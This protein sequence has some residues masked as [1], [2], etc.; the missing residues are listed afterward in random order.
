MDVLIIL[1]F[2]VAI[3]LCCMFLWAFLFFLNRFIVD[4][5]FVGKLA[6]PDPEADDIYVELDGQKYHRRY[7]NWMEWPSANRISDP[8]MIKQLQGLI[9]AG[10]FSNSP[11]I[12][13]NRS[14]H[15]RKLSRL[16]PHFNLLIVAVGVFAMLAFILSYEECDAYCSD[17]DFVHD[18][19]LQETV[20][21]TVQRWDHNPTVAVPN[22][23][24]LEVEMVGGAIFEL[25]ELLAD[26]GMS[27]RFTHEKHAD[28]VIS[29]VSKETAKEM[30]EEF[31]LDWRL[32]GLC[33]FKVSNEGSIISA[34]ILVSKNLS[35]GGKWGAVLHEFGHAIGV[36]GHTDR[37]YSSL[38]Y[39]DF[40]GGALSDRYSQ[41]DRKM[42]EF[43]YRRLQPGARVP[44]VRDAFDVHW[45]IRS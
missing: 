15:S 13:P 14:A 45:T 25:N 8:E 23:N 40:K 6:L 31:Y 27:L 41:D 20:R 29:F 33:N 16:R 42:L 37:Y 35:E 21:E 38:F 43:L 44:V 11:H 3:V 18:L 28:I 10:V 19:L 12:S 30:G 5:Y 32:E 7:G 1:G 39:E 17:W 26:T 9:F 34:K 36:T 22:G 24:S 2:I 4:G